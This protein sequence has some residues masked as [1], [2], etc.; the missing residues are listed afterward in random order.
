[1]CLTSEWHLRSLLINMQE[2]INKE[3]PA[4]KSCLIVLRML[5]HCYMLSYDD[6]LPE[7][8]QNDLTS[9]HFNTQIYIMGVKYSLESLKKKHARSS[10]SASKGKTNLISS[11]KSCRSCTRTPRRQTRAL[12]YLPG[13]M[14]SATEIGFQNLKT[15]R[16]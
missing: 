2:A 6:N 7:T 15:L 14:A 13:N 16:S 12:G 4:G 9:L 1:M 11:S 3:I 5:K 8:Q 10:D